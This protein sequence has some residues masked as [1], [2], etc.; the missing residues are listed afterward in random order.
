M[1][2]T[3]LWTKSP[4]RRRPKFSC[5][6]RPCGIVADAARTVTITSCV[7]LRGRGVVHMARDALP[8][9]STLRVIAVVSDSGITI[10]DHRTE[11]PFS[12]SGGASEEINRLS[13]CP[14][15]AR[16][17]SVVSVTGRND[18]GVLG[19]DPGAATVTPYEPRRRKSLTVYWHPIVVRGAHGVRSLRCL[20]SGSS[21]D[22]AW[23]RSRAT[24]GAVVD[25][26]LME[27][28]AVRSNK[29]T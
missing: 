7:S 1:A 21:D 6:L 29:S 26:W 25:V 17:D 12:S 11:R 22:G 8:T 19:F 14:E 2:I 16:I 4:A 27:T 18:A 28:C 5:P 3:G 15:R 13:G 23:D 10:L 20:R 24:D 9:W